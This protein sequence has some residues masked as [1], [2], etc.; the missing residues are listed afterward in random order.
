MKRLI[1]ILL[2]LIIPFLLPNPIFAQCTIKELNT[3]TSIIKKVITLFFGLFTKTDYSIQKREISTILIDMNDYGYEDDKNFDEKHAFAGSR[4][5]DANSQ[6]CF[7]GNII[8]Q[9]VIGTVGYKNTDL[10]QI[11][12]DNICSIISVDDLANYFIQTNQQFY[13]DN[14]NKLTDTESS[15]IDKVNQITNLADITIPESKKTCYQQIY[16]DFYITPK[17]NTDNTEENVKKIIQTPLSAASQNQNENNVE[18]KKRVDDF[19]TPANYLDKANGLNGLAPE[20]W[21]NQIPNKL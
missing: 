16:N 11:C 4:S 5:Q 8:K 2:L 10:A 13:C 6:N 20:S 15:F 1:I 14:K 18:I 12:L 19:F 9:A 3:Q 17:D 7:K 21:K